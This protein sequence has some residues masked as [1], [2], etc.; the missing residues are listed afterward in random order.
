MVVVVIRHY[1]FGSLKRVGLFSDIK[2]DSHVVVADLRKNGWM[3]GQKIC[4]VAV[5]ACALVDRRPGW[6]FQLSGK[7]AELCG[8]A[9]LKT[10]SKQ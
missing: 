7:V 3:V 10:D 8:F 1:E 6:G 2:Y 9:L 5:C 4:W